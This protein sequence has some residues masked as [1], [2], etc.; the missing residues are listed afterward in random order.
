MLANDAAKNIRNALVEYDREWMLFKQIIKKQNRLDR[1]D[2]LVKQ[3]Y[4]CSAN[5]KKNSLILLFGGI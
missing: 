5:V 1:M 3:L 2:G 4:E